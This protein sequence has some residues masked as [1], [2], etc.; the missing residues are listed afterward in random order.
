MSNL[1]RSLRTLPACHETCH[2]HHAML[3][4]RARDVPRHAR[5][6]QTTARR[7][8]SNSSSQALPLSGYYADIL[9]SPLPT[10]ASGNAPSKA[11][12]KKAGTA[13]ERAK[14]IFGSRLAGSGYERSS[15]TPDKTWRTINGVPIPPRPA[16]PDNCCMSG[17]VHCVWDDYRDEVED[18]AI[19]L[20][21][22][23]AKAQAAGQGKH[24]TSGKLPTGKRP[25]VDDASTS[26]D[27]DGGG[28]ET[29]WQ[30]GANDAE[31]LFQTIPVG[32]RE[33]MKTEKRLREMHMRERASS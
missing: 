29:N 17:C 12:S 15:R 3:W 10:N 32:I 5:G 11:S 31:D 30:F 22:A 4:R 7:H 28:S 26:M 9:D 1:G 8:G 2:T 20:R 33:F 14:V 23:Q 25:E 13:E 16:E 19:R 24:I 21:A 18:W 6:F 27:D